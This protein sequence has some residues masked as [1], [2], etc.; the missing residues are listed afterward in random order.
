MKT[1][2]LICELK[3]S[4]IAFLLIACIM[5]GL[6]YVGLRRIILDF[7][8]TQIERLSQNVAR[9][10]RD[11]FSQTQSLTQQIIPLLKQTH[12]DTKF[13]DA[14]IRHL[15]R[16]NPVI[17][18]ARIVLKTEAL[19][20]EEVSATDQTSHI[21]RTNYIS[22]HN[23]LRTKYD[24]TLTPFDQHSVP[25][26]DLT[27]T[28][29][30]QAVQTTQK[31]WISPVQTHSYNQLPGI[32]Y[33]APIIYE[34]KFQ[35]AVSIDLCLRDLSLF[36]NQQRFLPSTVNYLISENYVFA[37]SSM[38]HT[39]MPIPD[40]L[41]LFLRY[42]QKIQISK[43]KLVIQNTFET[44][45]Q[46]FLMLS[47]TPICD[48]LRPLHILYATLLSLS[49]ILLSLL[50]IGRAHSAHQISSVLSFCGKTFQEPRYKSLS[51]SRLMPTNI[52]EIDDL[53][54]FTEWYHANNLKKESFSS[55]IFYFLSEH[56]LHQTGFLAH[57]THHDLDLHQNTSFTDSIHQIVRDFDGFILEITPHHITIFWLQTHPHQAIQ[58]LIHITKRFQG[59]KIAIHTSVT[60]GHL[61]IDIIGFERKQVILKGSACKKIKPLK[62]FATHNQI[63]LCT[64]REMALL[65]KDYLMRQ[66]D[67]DV[68]DVAAIES[69]D[70]SRFAQHKQ[71]FF[72]RFHILYEM[73]L[74]KAPNCSREFLQLQNDHIEQFGYADILCTKLAH[75]CAHTETD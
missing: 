64:N 69:T 49:L 33:S 54:R 7:S 15:V 63:S 67:E 34:N 3:R 29:W 43:G 68:F 12:L 70:T 31:D 48:I 41:N 51:L 55:D 6:S 30:Y 53:L 37:K 22:T 60:T 52:Q 45:G 66:V 56:G 8:S 5:L 65:F 59:M 38:D 11:L 47:L 73:Y 42:P 20:T 16:Y 10:T 61:D 21:G 71:H 27:F 1:S 2:F 35:G 9:Q 18:A 57:C 19:Q 14:H 13:L 62:K 46:K 74:Q 28:P 39:V 75:E 23:T 25:L 32:T 24:Q 50:I 17:S 72:E 40:F 58:A 4:L 36:I 26:L 44:H